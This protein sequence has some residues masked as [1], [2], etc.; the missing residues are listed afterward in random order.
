MPI[1]EIE[2]YEL[3]MSKHRVEAESEAEAISK[4]FDD[5]ADPVDDSTEYI[6]VANDYGMPVDENQDLV[7]ELR[8]LGVTVGND[9]IESIRNVEEVE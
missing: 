3:Y 8:K 7:E 5:K 1:Y 9:V 2:Q 4:L 6:E